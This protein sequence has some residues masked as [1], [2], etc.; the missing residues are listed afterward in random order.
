MRPDSPPVHTPSLDVHA[1]IPDETSTAAATVSVSRAVAD[2][3]AG[4]MVILHG[5]HS[6]GALCMAADLVTPQAIN[7]MVTHAR[8]LVCLA[9]DESQFKRLGIPLMVPEAD[10]TSLQRTSFGV[11]IEAR[12]GVTTGISAYDRA[13]TIQTAVADDTGPDDLSR[14]GH[15]FP[16]LASSGGVLARV[17]SIEASVDLAQFAGRKSAA[18]IC[19]VINDDGS[20]ARTEDLRRFGKQHDIRQLWVSDLFRHRMASEPILQRQREGWVTSQFGEFR[21]VVFRSRLNGSEIVALTRGEIRPDLDT[22]VRLHPECIEGDLFASR[23]C[24]CGDALRNSLR[25]LAEMRAGVLVYLRGDRTERRTGCPTQRSGS[26]EEPGLALAV[27]V[28]RGLGARRILLASESLGNEVKLMSYGFEVVRRVSLDAAGTADGRKRSG[29]RDL[30][31]SD[32]F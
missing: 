13:H 31:R 2:I 11:S 19:H 24:A 7:F 8:G 1:V 22:W 6:D 9:L 16:L 17:D 14:P 18:V 29:L 27:N 20:A 10:N 4:Q 25:R 5:P 28:L 15:I 23:G 3:A 30:P 32:P 26:L 12:T 21:S